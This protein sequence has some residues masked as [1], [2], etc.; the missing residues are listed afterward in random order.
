MCP[1]IS[2]FTWYSST[3]LHCQF[4]SFIMN[5]V[6]IGLKFGSS[7]YVR[8]KAVNISQVPGTSCIIQRWSRTWANS[9]SFVIYMDTFW[10]SHSRTISDSSYRFIRSTISLTIS[11][12]CS[13]SKLLLDNLYFYLFQ[14]SINFFNSL[15]VVFDISLKPLQFG[16]ASVVSPSSILYQLFSKK[17]LLIWNALGC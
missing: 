1:E 17:P 9:I 12:E 5:L 2:G 8:P 16:T 3:G 14:S 4:H 10:T 11:I 13:Q 15:Q 6:S 7:E